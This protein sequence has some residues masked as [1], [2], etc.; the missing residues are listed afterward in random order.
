[1]ILK[2]FKYISSNE[3]YY[4]VLNDRIITM[5]DELGRMPQEAVT[6]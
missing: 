5:N 4:T 6:V 1:M 3:L 2:L